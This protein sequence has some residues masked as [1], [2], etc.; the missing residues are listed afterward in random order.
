M[1]YQLGDEE[2]TLQA[3]KPAGKLLQ[4]WRRLREDPDQSWSQELEIWGQ[5][6]AWADQVICAW[7]SDYLRSRFSQCIFI[8]DCLGSQWS[9][10]VLLRTWSNQQLQVPIAP[11]ATSQLQVA[12][13]HHHGQLKQ[14]IRQEKARLAAEWD[15]AAD[16]AGE[17][18]NTQWGPYHCVQV[19]AS[20][21]K[22]F[23]VY[24]EEH[25]LFLKAFIKNQLLIFRPDANHTLT[26]LDQLEEPWIQECLRFPP[27]RAITP[28]AANQR[29]VAQYTNHAER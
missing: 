4:G 22:R 15:Q 21:C 2:I 10:P 12:D 14:Y 11:N 23:R 1:T 19:L 3:G 9:E 28:A 24:Q 29:V 20:A 18:R 17:A 6:A 27:G 25:Q 13:T 16:R 8:V 5:P 26:L 7:V